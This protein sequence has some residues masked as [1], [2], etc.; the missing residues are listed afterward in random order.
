MYLTWLNIKIR[1]FLKDSM[2]KSTFWSKKGPPQKTTFSKF[3]QFFYIFLVL[4]HWAILKVQMLQK[5]KNLTKKCQKN[6]FW[7]KFKTNFEWLFEIFNI[8]SYSWTRY[9]HSPLFS[10]LPMHWL[11]CN[12]VFFKFSNT[13]FLPFLDP[14]T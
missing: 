13:T 14:S 7:N 10:D 9:A 1:W 12:Q 11:V 4:K 3:F 5:G 8:S 6:D 2:E